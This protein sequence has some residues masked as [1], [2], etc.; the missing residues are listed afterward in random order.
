M[1]N[2]ITVLSR[3]IFMFTGLILVGNKSVELRTDFGRRSEMPNIYKAL[4]SIVVWILFICGCV[5]TIAAPM[6]RIVQG[7]VFGALAAWAIG[8][9]CLILSVVAMKLRKS[10]E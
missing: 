1:D 2:I 10:L 8:I 6:S 4:A 5:A 3:N 9:A 7:E